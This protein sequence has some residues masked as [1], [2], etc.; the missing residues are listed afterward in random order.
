MLKQVYR[1]DLESGAFVE[2]VILGEGV[3]IPNDC[4]EVELPTPNWKPIWDGEKL[5]ETITPGELE[6]LQKPKELEEID[7]QTQL[8]LALAEVA[9]M[10]EKEKIATQLAIAELAELIMKGGA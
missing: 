1:Y 2:P 8:K 3:P 4:T 7:E 9:E 5:M 10:Q 6:D